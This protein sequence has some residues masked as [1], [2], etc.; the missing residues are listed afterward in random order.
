MYETLQQLNIL[1]KFSSI[2]TVYDNSVLI[3][4]EIRP[5]ITLV[6]TKKQEIFNNKML[7]FLREERN[8]KLKDCDYL[9][10]PDY[11]ILSDT[12]KQNWITYRQA[13]RDLPA[14]TFSLLDANGN[15]T[16]ITWPIPPS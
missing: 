12:I 13:L 10:H 2:N 7:D 8:K 9:L 14:I 5:D 15:L 3:D 4:G 16:N 6:D 1:D 11:P